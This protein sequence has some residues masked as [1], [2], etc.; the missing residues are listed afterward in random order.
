MRVVA[1]TEPFLSRDSLWREEI[2]W[3]LYRRMSGWRCVRRTEPSEK[4][5]RLD[6]SSWCFSHVHV[7]DGNDRKKWARETLIW[8]WCCSSV[9]EWCCLLSIEEREL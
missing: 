5:Y 2:R 1:C 3:M 7:K 9:V 8:R 4:V 6:S